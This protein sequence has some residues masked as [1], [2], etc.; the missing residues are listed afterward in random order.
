[1]VNY[2]VGWPSSLHKA[3]VIVLYTVGFLSQF[4]PL[5][6]HY[7]TMLQF[8][9]KFKFILFPIYTYL[10]VLEVLES[11]GTA[12]K[13]SRWPF[14]SIDSWHFYRQLT[15][16]RWNS[17]KNWLRDSLISTILLYLLG[18]MLVAAAI[19]I[20]GEVHNTLVC[21]FVLKKKD[22]PVVYFDDQTAIWGWHVN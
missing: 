6:F 17:Q 9:T 4:V 1:M 12:V 14:F 20:W 10:W 22:R 8:F 18:M 21:W 19:G 7:H 11:Q 3:Q 5:V 2:K 16:A 15:V 13:P